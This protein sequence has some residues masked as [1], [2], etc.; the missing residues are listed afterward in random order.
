MKPSLQPSKATLVKENISLVMVYHVQGSISYHHGGKHSTMQADKVL[1]EQ[2][3]IYFD[4]KAARRILSS[5][6]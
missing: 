6:I 2:R 3:F 5:T 1:E 4:P